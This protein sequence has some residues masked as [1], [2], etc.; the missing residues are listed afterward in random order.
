MHG[1]NS[2]G[3]SAQPGAKRRREC[4]KTAS[5][6]GWGNSDEKTAQPESR[7]RRPTGA[8]HPR[9]RTQ[10][11]P[12]ERATRPAAR[13]RID[14]ASAQPVH[15]M[16]RSWR[17]SRHRTDTACPA[18]VP[19]GLGRDGRPSIEPI[20]PVPTAR[21]PPG[22]ER[23]HRCGGHAACPAMHGRPGPRAR[24][25][26]GGARSHRTDTAGAQPVHEL[27]TPPHGSRGRNIAARQWRH[28]G[29]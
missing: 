24:S 15:A 20:Q 26:L 28:H 14:A 6:A 23:S 18:P 1:A 5:E 7:M 4:A 8:T 9:K 10:V 25:P 27:E 21:S 12:N 17:T 22:G 11:R 29:L 3:E 16:R 2:D 13:G 19:R